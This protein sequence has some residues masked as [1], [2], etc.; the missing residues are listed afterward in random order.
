M[1]CRQ[2]GT[3]LHG[4]DRFCTIC[5]VGQAVSASPF[6][7]SEAAF[8]SSAAVGGEVYTEDRPGSP[9]T[10]EVSNTIVWWLAF[11]P[12]L[13][14]FGAGFLGGLTH[15]GIGK[16]WW[17]TLVLNIVLSIADEKRL[18]KAGYNT[19][20]LGQA[21]LIPVYLFKRAQM[22]EQSK[23]YFIVWTVLFVLSL[24]GAL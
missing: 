8:Q 21:W 6:P 16:F 9:S 14:A 23:S 10:V 7:H 4:E 11:A 15:T 13:G 20:A 17:T 19:S 12:L 3:S 5:G 22:L 18:Q 1:F 2:C 24:F